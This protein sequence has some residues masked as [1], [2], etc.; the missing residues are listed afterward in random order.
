M[1][2]DDSGL[3][4]HR[5]HHEMLPVWFFVGI[6]LLFYGIV[7]LTAGIVEYKH[8][9]A[10]VLAQYHASLW[11]GVLLVLIGGVFTIRFF[12]RAMPRKR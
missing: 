8:P 6:L 12:P 1:A 4:V 2:S 3:S 9:P 10:V 11:G 5:E 7:V